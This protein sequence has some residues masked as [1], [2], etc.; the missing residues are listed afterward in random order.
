MPDRK[1]HDMKSGRGHFQE[2]VDIGALTTGALVSTDLDLEVGDSAVLLSEKIKRLNISYTLNVQRM[3]RSIEALEG[4]PIQARE[5]ECGCRL[6]SHKEAQIAELARG[7]GSLHQI[8]LRLGL[9]PGT[10][11]KHLSNIYF[12][13]MIKSRAELRTY[14][15]A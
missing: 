13:L 5:L 10:V 12:K 8:A 6:L 2:Q 1:C 3:L 4:I 11:R 15:H 9:E 14:W 7:N